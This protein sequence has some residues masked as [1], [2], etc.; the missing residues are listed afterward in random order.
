MTGTRNGYT[1]MDELK[2]SEE[3]LAELQYAELVNKISN[4]N[5]LERSGQIEEAKKLYQEVLEGDPAGNLGASA[6]KALESLGIPAK[7]YLEPI[8]K[9]ADNY[10]QSTTLKK[11][12]SNR[13]P[14]N[15][16]QWFF[17]LPISRKQL[18]ALV[19]SEIFALVLIGMGVRWTIENSLRNQ[20]LNQAKSEIAVT[21]INYNIKINQM[22]LGF[23]GQSDNSAIVAAAK[24]HQSG[25]ILDQDLRNQ[26][27]K[28]LQNEVKARQIEY[29]TLVGKDLRII[30]NANSDRRGE[31]FNPNNLVQEV[32][33]DPRQI[34]ASEIVSQAEINKEAPPVWPGFTP[35]N[36]LIRYT[37]TPVL[38]PTTKTVIAAL[39]S[40]D[41]VNGKLPIAQ[42]TLKALGGGY[43]AVYLHKTTGEFTLATALEQGDT[44]ALEQAQGNVGLPN[45]SILT[46]AAKAQDLPVTARITIG[47]QNYTVAV[48]ALPNIFKDGG[49]GSVPIAS[50]E[51]VAFLVR[52]TPETILN[53][54]LYQS[55]LEQFGVF[56]LALVVVGIWALILRQGIAIPI[57]QLQ[58]TTQAFSEGN[59]ETRA[60]VFATD[61]VGQLAM[62]FNQMADSIAVSGRVMEEQ[63][64]LRQAEADFQRQQKERL[65]QGVIDLLID[66]EGAQQGDLTVRA[67]IDEGDMGSIADAFNATIRNLREIVLQ[68]KT[69]AN[70]VHESAFSNEASVQKLSQEA[71]T[72]AQ[73]I[74]ETLNSVEDVGQ[75]IQSVSD[76]AIEAAAIA[77]Q[78]LVAAEDGDTTMDETVSSIGNIRASVAET[79]KKVKRLVESSQEISKIVNIISGISEKTNLLA[80]NASIEAS[81]AGQN[82]Q[83]FRV[84]ADE[85][86]KLAEKVTD[87]AKEIEQLIST[88]QQETAEVLQT[89]EASTQHVVTGTTLVTKTK[90]TL[91]GLAGISKKIDQLLQSISSSTVDQA[92]TSQMVNQK[93]QEVA[94]IAQTSSDESQAVSSSLQ[95]LVTVADKLQNSVSRFQVEK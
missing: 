75:S 65:Q 90:H 24:A 52:G 31:I 49:N 85:V 77:R 53:Q 38:D 40:G 56:F 73:V 60:T 16:W 63:A 6:Q 41:I 22:G 66:I 36:A 79:S 11:P 27:K 17:D 55:L 13:S 50:S 4:A 33:K 30:V 25:E 82:G 51:P 87:S 74:A 64:Q 91:Q 54:L 10:Q 46:A 26:V 12:K 76:A 43:S 23:R 39:V 2:E 94:A 1:N 93:M 42:E 70:Q 78:A 47:T 20:L 9:K 32:F 69:A 92:Q 45:T 19:S 37:V 34:K 59:Q 7:P 5:S 68:V 71:T 86:R 58:R 84:V 3:L 81:R 80:F 44:K 62:T 89:M 15:L 67:K 57:E 8:S 21:K 29:A 61:E 35:Q 14:L 18:I 95:Q 48:I 28:I 72:Q 83:G 88:I